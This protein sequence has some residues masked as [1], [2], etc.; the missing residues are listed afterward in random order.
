[1]TVVVSSL[2]KISVGV[3]SLKIRLY[4][5]QS[6]PK[7]ERTRPKAVVADVRRLLRS[8]DRR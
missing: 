1:M 6:L 2:C 7:L 5:K 8:S 4:V 3:E